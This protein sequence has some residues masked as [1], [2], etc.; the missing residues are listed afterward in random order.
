MASG[1]IENMRMN[2]QNT[3]QGNIIKSSIDVKV[4]ILFLISSIKLLSP[5]GS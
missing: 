3:L 4:Y 2:E 1:K 5:I